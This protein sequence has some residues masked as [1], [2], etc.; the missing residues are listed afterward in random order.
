MTSLIRFFWH[1]LRPHRVWVLA[2]AAVMLATIALQLATPIL[3]GRF[4]DDALG[5]EPRDGLLTIAGLVLL[6]AVS[7]QFLSVV[8][9]KIAE[10]LSWSATNAV[11]VDLTSHLLS[12]DYAFHASHTQGELIERVDGDIGRLARFFSRFAINVVGNGILMLAI[13]WLLLST[14]WRVAFGI[15]AIISLAFGSMLA[16]R[17]R[18]TPAWTEERETAAGVYGL[19]SDYLDGL[20]S[21]R[22]GGEGARQFVIQRF[23]DR[24]REWLRVSTRAGMWGYALM[25]TTTGVF[26]LALAFALAVGGYLHRSDGLTLGSLFL[27]LR[28][29]DMLREPVRQLRNEIQDFQQAAASMARVRAL[30]AEQ[31]RIVDGFGGTL[32]NGPLSIQWRDVTFGY[33]MLSPVLRNISLEVPA[34][35][36]LG[37]VGRTGSGKSTLTRLLPRFYDPDQGTILI[38]GVDIR[39]LRLSELRDTVGIVSQDVRLFDATL[40]DNLTIFAPSDAFPDEELIATLERIGLGDWIRTLPAGL[41]SKIGNGGAG[42]SAGQAQLITCARVLLRD[43]Q[44]VVL[45]EASARLDPVSERLLHQ[46]IAELLTGRTGVIVAHRLDTL[47]LADDIAVIDDGELIEHGSRLSLMQ[48]PGSRFSELLKMQTLA[49]PE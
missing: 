2:L 35:R 28:V 45:D 14:D 36:I 9:T 23:L 32:P 25:A 19:L 49:V 37:I 3:S 12:L 13:L 24:M 39:T 47:A 7:A 41:D 27:I 38:G 15:A 4:I 40:R 20:E 30:L 26:T 43:P 42:V 33:S 6:F 22:A 29:T 11:R 21:V 17:K 10:E 18:A 44:I 31:P 46:A 48:D 1:Y 34:G 8:E 5:G 16:I